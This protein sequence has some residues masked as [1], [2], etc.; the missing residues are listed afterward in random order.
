MRQL[1]TFGYRHAVLISAMFIL[2]VGWSC[3][4]P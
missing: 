4:T 3:A 2:N 1:I